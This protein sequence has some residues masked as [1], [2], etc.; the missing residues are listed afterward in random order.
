MLPRCSTCPL[1]TPSPGRTLL[2]SS[3]P[4]HQVGQDARIAR[5]LTDRLKSDRSVNRL[6]G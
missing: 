4:G 3:S 6:S 5:I 2:A 1:A